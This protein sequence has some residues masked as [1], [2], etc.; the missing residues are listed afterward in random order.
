[1][2]GTAL[3]RK[4]NLDDIQSECPTTIRISTH[5]IYKVEL[6]N[7]TMKECD[8]YTIVESM[9]FQVDDNGKSYTLLIENVD[10]RCDDKDAK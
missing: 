3:Q 6:S 1:M 5:Y 4:R 8:A 10:Q 2:S 7:S 9:Y